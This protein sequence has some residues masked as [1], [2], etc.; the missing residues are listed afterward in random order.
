MACVRRKIPEI[1]SLMMLASELHLC[2]DRENNRQNFRSQGLMD[3]R[4]RTFNRILGNVQDAFVAVIATLF[5]PHEMIR[6]IDKYR[7]EGTL[8]QQAISS[9]VWLTLGYI[10]FGA[11][12]PYLVWSPSDRITWFLAAFFIAAAPAFVTSGIREAFHR[13]SAIYVYGTRRQATVTEVRYRGYGIRPSYPTITCEV[14]GCKALL[15]FVYIVQGHERDQ[16]YYPKVGDV[17]SVYYHPGGKYKIAPAA[18]DVLEKSSLSYVLG[19]Y[20]NE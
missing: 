17:I 5:W 20:N 2:Y 3:R 18:E 9:Y 14:E 4:N 12:L 19:E 16:S 15:Q 1:A 10:M 6:L 7:A 13:T 8:N 11:L